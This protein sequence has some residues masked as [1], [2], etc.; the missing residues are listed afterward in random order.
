VESHLDA[1]RERDRS[2]ADARLKGIPLAVAALAL[3][4]AVNVI[5]LWPVETEDA[6]LVLRYAANLLN[7]GELVFNP[8]ERVSAL[9]SPLHALAV[10]TL[11]MG[12]EDLATAN[13]GL[14]LAL[15]VASVG[16]LGWALRGQ[17]AALLTVLAVAAASPFAALWA[18]GGLETPLLFAITTALCLTLRGE[19]ARERMRGAAVALAFALGGMAFVTRYDSALVTG[20]ILLWVALRLG[21]RSAALPIACGAVAPLSWMAFSHTYFGDW[22]PTSFY[23]KTP[24]P[25]WASVVYTFE[26]YL[27]SGLALLSIVAIAV[28]SGPSGRALW[29]EHWRVQGWAYAGLAGLTAYGLIASATHMFYSFR[30]FVP[31]LPLAALP[32]AD[33]LQRRLAASPPDPAP[34]RAFALGI[35]LVVALQVVNLVAVSQPNGNIGGGRTGEFRVDGVAE[36]SALVE[37]LRAPASR[38]REHWAQQPA[39]RERPMRVKTFAAGALPYALPEAYVYTSLASY[40]HHC[41]RNETQ[42][43]LAAD[44]ITISGFDL[45][46]QIRSGRF[47]RFQVLT[48]ADGTSYG[49]IINHVVFFNPNPIPHTLSASIDEPCAALDRAP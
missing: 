16:A 19:A 8:G 30:L 28:V 17:R 5:R 27:Y 18:V 29:K 12:F 3:L 1:E 33:L 13:K 20:P 7:H 38:I 36:I 31:F 10:A 47:K 43:S 45:N 2:T 40:R 11:G 42:L 48:Q 44:Y 34:R 24:S 32:C 26:V 15:F 9:T 23:L 49:Q 14:G 39:S 35:G 25:S 21:W 46:R 4:C 22:L 6:Y 37:D 41:D